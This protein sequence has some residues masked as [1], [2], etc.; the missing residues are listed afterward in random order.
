M[1]DMDYVKPLLAE[2]LDRKIRQTELISDVMNEG[3]IKMCKM[4]GREVSPYEQVIAVLK[5]YEECKGCGW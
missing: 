2:V 4:L 1:L 3:R 5:E